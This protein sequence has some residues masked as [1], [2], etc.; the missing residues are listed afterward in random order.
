[1]TRRTSRCSAIYGTAF[2][3]DKE[4]QAHLARIEE[5]KKRDHRK[6]GKDLGLFIVHPWAPGAA[7]WLGKGT[8]L[9]NTLANY[10]RSVL[11]PAGYEEVKTPLVYNKALWETSGHWSYYRENMFLVQSSDDEEMAL[12]SMNCPGHFLVFASEMRSY[13][14]LPLRFHEQTPLH[15]NE[16]SGVLSGLTRV[17]QFSQ[18]DA[19]CFV[20]ESQIAD[21]VE[22]LIRLVQRV[23]GDFGLPY[24][25]KLA[26]RPDKFLGDGRDLGSRRSV[27]AQ[28]RSTPRTRPYTVNE[29]DGAF[30]GPKI[31]FDITDAIGRQWQCATIQLDYQ[32][33]ERFDLKYIG[34]DNTEHRP[35]VIH[36]AI[37]GSF[38]RFIAILIEHYAGAFPLWL[39]PV[40]VRPAADRG[41]PR[42]L[43]PVG[44]GRA[45]RRPGCGSSSTSGR[46][47]LDI[48][49]AKP[50]CRR[51]RT[52][53]SPAIGK[54]PRAP[55]RCG[56]GA[57][58]TW[59]RAPS[60]NS[61]GRRRRKSRPR[62][63]PKDWPR[64]ARDST[65][66]G[67]GRG[68]ASLRIP[69]PDP[70]YRGFRSDVGGFIAFDRSPRRDD[71]TR[72]NERIRV[73][74]VRVIDED[75]EQLGIMP[76]P[77]ALAIARQKGL[78]LV[79]IAATA[80]PPVCRIMDFGRYQY[81]E[82]KRARSAKK[83]QKIIEVKEI[84]F[85]PKVDEHDYQF[86]KKHIE[87]FLADGDKVKATI[88]FRGRE[89][90]HPE[91]GRRILERLI[92]D[93]AEVA[94]AGEHAAAGRQPDAHD[95]V[96]EGRREEAGGEAE[97]KPRA[98]RNHHAEAKET[99]GRREALQ[100]D[101]APAS[102]SGAR[103]SRSTS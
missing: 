67:C 31:D 20:T 33:P 51:F 72:V 64:P 29:G 10:M 27:A 25:V 70:A 83:H 9:Y 7:F 2:F 55:C 46:R 77:Q 68:D 3:S 49:S 21:E 93:L 17:R 62:E 50:S 48:R 76:P 13:R 85:R 53:W 34:A 71:R 26:T 94:I 12:K 5:A 65:E 102:S 66:S 89:M 52:C 92:D 100:E 24:T 82:Q 36:R 73:R 47:R 37:F 101:G 75:G 44:A 86:K 19:H 14:D 98:T 95:P 99:S 15:R 87:R 57:A 91:I 59:A 79:E 39:A 74:E 63:S 54:S 11:F 45:R 80:V 38:E 56:A 43:R 40:Q 32:M 1:M 42:G 81:Q 84:K 103:P 28:G 97:A 6:L 23:Y 35:I 16:A 88:F 69:R 61:F 78:D 41:P 4:L 90:A 96:A 30:Y 60:T 22:Q 8:T 58:G 18:D